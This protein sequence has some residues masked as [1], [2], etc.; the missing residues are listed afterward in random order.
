MSAVLRP[1][2]TSDVAALTAL[3][4]AVFESDRISAKSFLH[5]V[6]APSASVVV[7]D[8]EGAIAGYCVVL[9]RRNGRSARLYSIAV[10]SLGQ[11]AGVG[12]ALLDA[13]ERSAQEH[14]KAA[15]RL[16]V[17]KDNMRAIALYERRGYVGVGVKPAYYADRTDALL[18]TKQ[19]APSRDVGTGA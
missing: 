14:G 2:L 18:Y 16:E 12:Q 3:E 8:V 7:A 10:G 5:L 15:L 11:G 13:A 17:R 19:L 9:F 1:A 6:A 4:N